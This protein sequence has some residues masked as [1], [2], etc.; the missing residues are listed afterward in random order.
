VIYRQSMFVIQ[1]SKRRQRCKNHQPKS[2][3][4][5]AKNSSAKKYTQQTEKWATR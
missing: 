4:V 2:K 5:C 1:S 3:W